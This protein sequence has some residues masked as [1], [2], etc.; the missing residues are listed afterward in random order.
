MFF[1]IVP[2]G[3]FMPQI[4]CVSVLVLCVHLCSIHKKY[5]FCLQEPILGPLRTLSPLRNTQGLGRKRGFLWVQSVT[6]PI[7]GSP[8][9]FPDQRPRH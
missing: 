9:P 7:W 6:G 2:H 5:F 4:C 8:Q 3:I 1:L